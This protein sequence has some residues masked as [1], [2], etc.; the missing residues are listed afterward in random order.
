M[1][2]QA[3]V[4]LGQCSLE[5]AE[6]LVAGLA[7]LPADSAIVELVRPAPG[8]HPDRIRVSV[9][10]PLR[11]VDP[12]GQET[13]RAFAG[14][15]APRQTI[16]FARLRLMSD[17]LARG[18]IAMRGPAFPLEDL[19]A[20][21]ASAREVNGPDIVET[22][23]QLEDMLVEE[24]LESPDGAPAA[25]R[26]A[27]RFMA[28]ASPHDAWH[29]RVLAAVLATAALAPRLDWPSDFN[30]EAAWDLA[31]V[32][33]GYDLSWKD[34]A[35]ATGLYVADAVPAAKTPDLEAVGVD[36]AG[37]TDAT[38]EVTL[39]PGDAPADSTAAD[40]AP[41]DAPDGAGAPD[42]ADV[43]PVSGAPGASDEPSGS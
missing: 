23:L 19:G 7:G 17:A 5:A 15:F 28:E 2:P 18:A 22:L 29:A 31:A 30:R 9:D 37:G 11:A 34:V 43:E 42:V 32:V 20:W 27:V 41:Q 39:R 26:S 12:G 16:D 8:I 6:A 40:V 1:L 35:L 21:L 36:L 3:L 25:S 38:V 13:L 4:A 24:D 10:V 33:L 14:S